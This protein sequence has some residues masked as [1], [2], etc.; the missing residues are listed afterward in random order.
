MRARPVYI[1]MAQRDHADDRGSDTELEFYLPAVITPPAD[2]SRFERL[3]ALLF[4]Q[5]VESRD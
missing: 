2:T 1:N 4:D 3:W 5:D